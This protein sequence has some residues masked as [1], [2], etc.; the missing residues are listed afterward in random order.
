MSQSSS[1]RGEPRFL[2]AARLALVFVVASVITYALVAV[3][4]RDG[5]PPQANPPTGVGAVPNA[6]KAVPNTGKAAPN[7]WPNLAIRWETGVSSVTVPAEDLPPLE[8][9]R[10]EIVRLEG[11]PEAAFNPGRV[12]APGETT[13]ITFPGAG[14]PT[15]WL[16]VGFGDQSPAPK[17]TLTVMIDYK[18][19]GMGP[20]IFKANEAGRVMQM[21]AAEQNRLLK[22]RAMTGVPPATAKRINAAIKTVNKKLGELGKLN[23]L[24]LKT[25]KG[26]AKVHY[27]IYTVDGDEEQTLFQSDKSASETPPDNE[28][29]KEPETENE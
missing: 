12:L 26:R 25:C 29:D 21:L 15:F 1:P 7:D 20:R 14:L 28:I 11:L 6:G 13:E 22:H 5:G 27:R 8:T 4:L 18:Q 10:L 9:L 3:F 2:T 24:H 16:E 17:I 19:P 23:G